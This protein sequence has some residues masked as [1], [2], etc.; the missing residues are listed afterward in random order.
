M[1]DFS[2]DKF[3]KSYRPKDQVND[4]KDYLRCGK[5]DGYR[6]WKRRHG[7]QVF[8]PGSIYI[9]YVRHQDAFMD[10]NFGSHIKGGMLAGGGT[11]M[12]GRF[13]NLPD[14]DYW[15]HLMLM[16]RKRDGQEVYFNISLRTNYIFY[17]K[18]ST[19]SDKF[20]VEL[21]KLLDDIK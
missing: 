4:V 15:T 21:K 17:K 20:K 6:L 11:Y 9:K 10:E 1:E 7:I 8:E 12:N 2:L 3:L 18:C 13:C 5:L 16:F 14:K 19:P